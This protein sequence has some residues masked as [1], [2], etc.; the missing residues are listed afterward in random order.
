MGADARILSLLGGE[1]RKTFIE[2]PKAIGSS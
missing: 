2:A 1:Q